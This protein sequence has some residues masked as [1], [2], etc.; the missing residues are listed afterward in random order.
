MPPHRRDID[1]DANTNTTH[2][3]PIP[4]PDYSTQETETETGAGVLDARCQMLDRGAMLRYI[5]IRDPK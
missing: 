3:D 4:G 2:P 1:T 5:N